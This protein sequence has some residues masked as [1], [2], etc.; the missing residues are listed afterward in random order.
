ML[1]TRRF[2]TTMFSA[3]QRCNIDA[4]LLRIVTTRFQHCNAVLC[5]EIVAANRPVYITFS[6]TNHNHPPLLTYLLST[7]ANDHLILF[8]LFYEP[9]N[10][11]QHHCIVCKMHVAC[12]FWTSTFLWPMFFC[13]VFKLTVIRSRSL[14][15]SVS[16]NVVLHPVCGHSRR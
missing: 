7:C 8:L 5:L 4:T 3:T 12:S 1:L 11:W 10:N 16:R 2:A 9:S 13:L 15:I 14:A 6:Q